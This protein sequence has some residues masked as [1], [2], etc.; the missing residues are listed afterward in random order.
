MTDTHQFK[1]LICE[2]VLVSHMN[3][4]QKWA[5]D[6]DGAERHITELFTAVRCVFNQTATVRRQST[7]TM[8]LNV[9]T[10]RNVDLGNVLSSG[11]DLHQKIIFN[12]HS[13]KQKC[14][15]TSALSGFI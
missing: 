1:S 8:I 13:E 12:L 6:G 5:V 10:V 11:C 7:N 4:L 2:F 3:F 15:D 14:V 9:P